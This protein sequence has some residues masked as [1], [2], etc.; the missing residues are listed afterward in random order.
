MAEAAYDTQG[1]KD[2][3]W[4]IRLGKAIFWSTVAFAVWFFYWFNAI[5]CPC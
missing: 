2:P 5:Q 3:E 1:T 4:K